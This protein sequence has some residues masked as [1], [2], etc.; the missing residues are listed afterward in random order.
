[1]SSRFVLP[2]A[3]RAALA[4]LATLTGCAQMPADGGVGALNQL[5]QP[6]L[7]LALPTPPAPPA[8]ESQTSAAAQA[9]TEV[10]AQVQALMAQPLSADSAVQLMLLNAPAVRVQ[11]LSLGLAEADLVA[12]SR[13]PNPGLSFARL[14]QGSEVEIDRGLSINLSRLLTWPLVRQMESNR[15]DQARL[16]TAREVLRLAFETRQAFYQA[17]AATESLQHARRVLDTA[18]VGSE[19][20]RRMRAAGNWNRLKESTELG[21]EAEA[22][23]QLKRAEL[24]QVSA[25]EAL[26]RLLGVSTPEAFTLPEHLPTLPAVAQALPQ[27]EQAAVNQRLDVQ[28]TRLH[29]EQ[30]A[31]S[32]G[33]TRLAGF[34][35][36]LDLQAGV[37]SNSSREAPRQHGYEVSL[38]LPLFDWGELRASQMQAQYQQAVLEAAHMAQLARSEVR[39]AHARYLAQHQLARHDLDTVLPLRKQVSQEMLLRYNGML[40]GVFELLADAREQSRSVQAAIESQRD[41]WIAQAALDFALSRPSTSA[42]ATPSTPAPTPAGH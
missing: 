1:M 31:K 9:Q 21:F 39:E 12:A 33:A 5:T 14:K 22:L 20:A 38:E 11:L 23:G 3:V 42:L 34:V 6:R 4:A 10:Q 36:V 24:A 35:N 27:A 16:S 40:I 26:T 28:A 37:V 29:A 32:A 13:L 41:A 18:Q 25:L 19:L 17:V 2:M 8:S 15:L 7:G 30:L